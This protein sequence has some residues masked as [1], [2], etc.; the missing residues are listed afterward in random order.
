MEFTLGIKRWFNILNH[1]II[2]YIDSIKNK[3]HMIISK[4]AEK[5]GKT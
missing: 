1:N 2:Y 5:H 3:N 4:N